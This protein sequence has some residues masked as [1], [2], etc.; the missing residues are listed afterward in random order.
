MPGTFV[1]P[2]HISSSMNAHDVLM[3]AAGQEFMGYVVRRAHVICQLTR[4]G[5]VGGKR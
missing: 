5:P 1:H 4:G 2:L 3:L